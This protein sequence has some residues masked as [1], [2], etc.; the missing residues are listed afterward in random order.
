MN[1]LHIG[2]MGWSYGFWVGK[3]YPEGTASKGFL[4]EYSRNF[5]TVE[6][7][8]TFYR[9]PSKETV[10]TWKEQTPEGFLFSAKFPRI[11]THVKMLQKCE[12]EVDM[13]I[14]RISQLQSK[15]GPLLLQFPSAFKPEHIP[16]LRDFLPTLPKKHRF[17]VEVRNRKLLKEAFYSVLRENGVALALVDSPFVPAVEVMSTDFAYIRWEGDRRKVKGLLGQVEFDRTG[18]ITKWAERIKTFL[19]ASKEVFGYFSKYYSGYP[20]N[21]AKELLSFLGF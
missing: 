21:D 19:D 18:S 2:T 11:I 8:S 7:D 3:L 12:E 4:L 14:E 9:I 17:V 10:I 13:F 20:S 16:L 1:R 5:N 15:L 6:I